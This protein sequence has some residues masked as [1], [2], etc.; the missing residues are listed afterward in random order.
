M[1]NEV[2]IAFIS[3]EILPSNKNNF[4]TNI[5][6]IPHKVDCLPKIGENMNYPTSTFQTCS[7]DSQTL[8]LRK[9]HVIKC[10]VQLFPDTFIGKDIII[11]NLLVDKIKTV[12]QLRDM[13]VHKLNENPNFGDFGVIKMGIDGV[14]SPRMIRRTFC[15]YPL[16]LLEDDCIDLVKRNLNNSG[17]KWFFKVLH[18]RREP[19]LTKLVSNL[20]AKLCL[21][22]TT[23]E[24][25]GVDYFK[26]KDLPDDINSIIDSFLSKLHPFNL[27]QLIHRRKIPQFRERYF[28]ILEEIKVPSKIAVELLTYCPEYNNSIDKAVI[29]SKI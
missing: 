13:I 16:N 22:H 11:W 20:V 12:Y 10:I 28:E 15:G 26:K 7:I 14:P 4:F 18:E 21:R 8:A 19:L 2:R 29:F 9:L 23:F 25:R 17:V 3:M 5:V 6:L 27:V 24:N 1:D